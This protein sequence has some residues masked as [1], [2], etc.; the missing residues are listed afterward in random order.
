MKIKNLIVAG[1]IMLSVATFAQK[2][3]LKTL[4]KLY[5]KDFIKGEDLATYK[6]TIS[7]LETLA[8]EEG[9]KVYTNFYSFPRTTPSWCPPAP[10]PG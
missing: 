3:E 6:A 7:K 5:A 10:A 1:T 8:T 4:K 9:D 2:D